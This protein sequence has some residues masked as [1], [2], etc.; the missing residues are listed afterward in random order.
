[1]NADEAG[2]AEKEFYTSSYHGPLPQQ[3]TSGQSPGQGWTQTIGATRTHGAHVADKVVTWLLR[4]N[5]TV[6]CSL[7]KNIG[8]YHFAALQKS[9]PSESTYK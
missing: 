4:E 2:C 7:G 9:R 8:Q 3:A 1:M 5:P 6:N